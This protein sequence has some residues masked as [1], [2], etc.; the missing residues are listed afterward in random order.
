MRWSEDPSTAK[1]TFYPMAGSVTEQFDNLL[2]TLRWLETLKPTPKE[3]IEWL[4]TTFVLSSYFA[5]NVYTVLLTSS[6]LVSV[7]KGRCYLTR[8]GQSV[9]DS[10]SP[11]MLLEVFEEH[12]VGMFACLEALRIHNN[13]NFETLRAMWLEA[14]KERFP[15]VQNWS[16]R[17]LGNQCR[18]RINWLR[19][20]G[21]VTSVDGRYAL[22]ESGWEFILIN[23]PEVSTIQHQEISQQE[24]QLDELVLGQFQLFD[25]SVQKERSSRKVFARNNAFRRIVTTQYEHYCAVCGFRLKTSRGGYEAEAAHIIPKHKNGVDDPRNGIS[26]CR[27]HHWAFDKG[28]IS[29]R[30]DDL[31]VIIASYL[32][33]QKSDTSVQQILRLHGRR[34]RS[35]ANR[36]YLPAVGALLWHNQHIFG[37]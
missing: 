31:T 5:R 3:T 29:V 32:G 11:A 21:L 7:R 17:T 24:T 8:D 30:P 33:D 2:Q 14:V 13:V 20:M 27:T 12:F 1:L 9:L 15:Q 25:R 16:K 23:A 10:A 34:I 19:A 26:L 37:D 4:Q 6:G 28:V 22:S 35:V 36:A 18:H